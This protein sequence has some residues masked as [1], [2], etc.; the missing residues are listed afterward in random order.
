MKELMARMKQQRLARVGGGGGRVGVSLGGRGGGGGGGGEGG[1]GVSGG[2]GGGG[3]GGGMGGLG[4]LFGS[5]LDVGGGGGGGVNGGGGMNGMMVNYIKSM[6]DS[7]LEKMLS[8]VPPPTVPPEHWTLARVSGHLMDAGTPLEGALGA[9]LL[10]VCLA[11]PIVRLISLAV[12][13]RGLY[14]LTRSL[15]A[16]GFNPRT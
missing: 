8:A 2:G 11:A 16:P 14:T 12:L 6:S 15:K 1:G 3:G 10:L 7:Q 9:A 5:L 13:W 4:A